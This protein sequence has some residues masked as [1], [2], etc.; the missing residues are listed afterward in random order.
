MTDELRSRLWAM[1]DAGSIRREMIAVLAQ[2]GIHTSEC[3]LTQFFKPAL[4]EEYE[5][6]KAAGAAGVLAKAVADSGDLAGG[7]QAVI[8]KAF[9]DMIRAAQNPD[10]ELAQA[11]LLNAAQV[12]AQMQKTA[13]DS[14]TLGL[15]QQELQLAERRVA[16][17]EN[18]LAEAKQVVESQTLSA[19]QQ[20]M[21]LKEI[22]QK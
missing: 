9:F 6:S 19:E 4:R 8:G 13:H 20:R 12:F 1:E 7:G 14:A 5:I 21:R 2:H 10:P 18:K 11:T 22:F 3:K 15:K 16:V 17:I